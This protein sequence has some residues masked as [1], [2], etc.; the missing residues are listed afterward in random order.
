[1]RRRS[2]L[3]RGGSWRLL[4]MLISLVLPYPASVTLTVMEYLISPSVRNLTTTAEPITEPSIFFSSTP[5]GLSRLN[6]RSVTPL[7]DSQ[8]FSMRETVWDT[9]SRV[10]AIWMVMESTTLLQAHCET[11]TTELTEGPSISCSST[12]TEPSRQSRRS[13][14]R[15]GA[16]GYHR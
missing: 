16:H 10:S 4:T 13:V 9:R 6:K 15:G 14:Y 7:E 12:P 5:T 1:M 2:A 11:T 3:S 8:P